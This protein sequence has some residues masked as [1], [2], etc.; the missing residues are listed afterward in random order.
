MHRE[1]LHA[2]LHAS[3]DR[4]AWNEANGW[5]LIAARLSNN[6][7]EWGTTFGNGGPLL[8]AKT[9]PPGPILAAKFGPGRPVSGEAEQGGRRGACP[10]N[11]HNHSIG[12]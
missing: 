7:F 5:K 10:P 4:H 6:P 1:L 8:A 11:F 12:L 3:G 9:G 2:R